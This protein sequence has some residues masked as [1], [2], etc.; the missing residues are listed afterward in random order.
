MLKENNETAKKKHRH[1]NL[2]SLKKKSVRTVNKMWELCGKSTLKIENSFYF[3][4]CVTFKDSWIDCHF[5]SHRANHW[6]FISFRCFL[7]ENKLNQM[8][9]WYCINYSLNMSLLSFLE[10]RIN[11]KLNKR[12]KLLNVQMATSSHHFAFKCNLCAIVSNAKPICIYHGGC[13]WYVM[14]NTYTEY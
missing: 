6:N 7:Y 4:K 1:T 9:R 10:R 14:F 13:W 2:L 5:P 8:F 3:S 11:S 12:A